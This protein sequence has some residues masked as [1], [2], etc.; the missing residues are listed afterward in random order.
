MPFAIVAGVP[1]LILPVLLL[2]GAVVLMRH[3]ADTGH[4]PRRITGGVL[5]ALAVTGTFQVVHLGQLVGPDSAG[6]RKLAGGFLGWV[7]TPLRAGLTT[8]PAVLVLVLAG[9]FGVLL[10]TGTAL[11]DV[12][13]GVGRLWNSFRVA[14]AGDDLSFD[15]EEPYL[16]VEADR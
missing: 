15:D 8:V 13:A 2:V 6:E 7:G 12:P 11:R 16:G 10:V 4:R 3:P 9:L 14:P 1:G 5:T